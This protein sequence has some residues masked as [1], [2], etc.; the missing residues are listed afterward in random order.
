MLFRR[1]EREPEAQPLSATE[2]EAEESASPEAALRDDIGLYHLWFLEMRLRDELA[3]GGRI[4]SFFS[5]ATWQLRLLPGEIPGPELLRQ[6]AAHIVSSL[7]TYDIPAR[8]DEHRFVALLLDANY[9]AA[10]T[11]AFRIK[12]D[13]QIRL[14]S[15]GRW[16]A[17]VSTFPDD[18]VDGNGLIQAAFR[19]LDEDARAAS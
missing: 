18:G 7:R 6:S 13:I 9:Q 4:G 8:I 2:P 15:A 5:L 16:Q 17:G 3:R 10:S 11:V 1:K 12:G 19:R 14:Q